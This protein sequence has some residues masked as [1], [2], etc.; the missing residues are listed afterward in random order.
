M[1]SASFKTIVEQ[2]PKVLAAELPYL[3][4]LIEQEIARAGTEAG[5]VVAELNF[6]QLA[7]QANSMLLAATVELNGP[8][9][10]LLVGVVL[11][12]GSQFG[13]ATSNEFESRQVSS[14]MRRYHRT[15]SNITST[16]DSTKEKGWVELTADSDKKGSH[17]E[18]RVTHRGCVEVMRLWKRNEPTVAASGTR[19]SSAA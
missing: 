17:K 8:E 1:P 9:V 19:P 10:A 13:Q 7:E 5:E 14:E 11:Q 2:L 6:E 16:M 12:Y 18:Y 4:L 3:Q 15:V